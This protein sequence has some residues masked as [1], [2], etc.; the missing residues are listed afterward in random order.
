[1]E[2]S[3][4]DESYLCKLEKRPTAMDETKTTYIMMMKDILLKKKDI[5]CAI[6]TLTGQQ[7]VLLCK[8]NADLDAF[9]EILPKKEKLIRQLER[10]DRGFDDTYRKVQ[11]E[12]NVNKQMYKKEILELQELIRILTEQSVILQAEEQKNKDRM[13]IVFAEKRRQVKDFKISSRTA[14]N[15]YKNMTGRPQGE[16]YFMDKRK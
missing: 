16:S 6:Q 7:T 8:E 12:L 3:Y 1:M 10:L 15:Y 14:S 13:Q 5:L 11:A 4:A 2:G 9:E